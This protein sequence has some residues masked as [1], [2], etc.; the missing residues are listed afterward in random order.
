MGGSLKNSCS[1]ILIMQENMGSRFKTNKKY[2][3]AQTNLMTNSCL[4]TPPACQYRPL[5][6]QILK[7][8]QQ[9]FKLKKLPWSAGEKVSCRLFSVYLLRCLQQISILNTWSY[10]EVL[11]LC[12]A[13]LVDSSAKQCLLKI[14]S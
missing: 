1:F 10:Q 8:G 3:F 14:L 11:Q 12:Q 2:Y 4:R 7:Q 9:L 5:Q 6:K 13:G